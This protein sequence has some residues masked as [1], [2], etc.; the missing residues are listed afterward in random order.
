MEVNMDKKYVCACGLI[1]S[2]CLFYKSEIY[3]TAKKLKE[4][5]KDSQLDV[6][7]KILSKNEVQ[8]S[9]AAH[10]GAD[11]NK[12]GEYFEPFK[13]LPDFFNVLD[14]IINIQCKKTCQESGG[15]SMGGD[16]KYC[17]AV[18]CVKQKGYNGCWE[19]PDNEKCDKLTFQKRSYGKTIEENFN[20]IK[21]KGVESVQSRGNKY[22]EWQ[23]RIK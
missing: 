12:F 6:F 2:D 11:E 10:L 20:M 18:K 19:C 5:I 7:L 16:T 9:M 4:L 23:R 3:D 17:E 1:C 14:G 15:C 8:R 22:Y 13:N 21:E